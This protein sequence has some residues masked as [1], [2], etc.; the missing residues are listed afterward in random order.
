MEIIRL[1]RTASVLLILTIAGCSSETQKA[2]DLLAD[3]LLI[4]S[5][6]EFQDVKSYPGEAVCG[7]FTATTSY[8]TRSVNQPFI[9][10]RET[11]D[12]NPSDMD[13]IIFCDRDPAA[14]LHEQ[15][16]IG[17]FDQKALELKKITNDIALLSGAMEQYYAEIFYY[18][19][20]EQGLQALV[21]KPESGNRLK[22]YR[23]GRYLKEIPLDPWGRPYLYS[24]VRW[25]RVKG[26]FEISTL[27]KS[28]VSGGSGIE[29]DV[30]SNYLP[31]LTHITK[32]I[33]Q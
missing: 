6:L 23:E 28:G 12:K 26:P 25:G 31:Y 8:T 14:R 10:Y 18:P 30:S 20:E 4:T 11:L 9:V 2:K 5:D 19:T 17:P 24:H 29:A 21:K 33:D 3:S 32:T 7:S 22:N 13:W 1:I 27:G 15:T 16:G